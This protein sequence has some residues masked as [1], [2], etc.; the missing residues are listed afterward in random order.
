MCIV[1]MLLVYYQMSVVRQR[2]GSQRQDL[3]SDV[4]CWYST[5]LL[6]RFA[7]GSGLQVGISSLHISSRQ[8][9][10]VVIVLAVPPQQQH[11]TPRPARM[12][13]SA[14]MTCARCRLNHS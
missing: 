1:A 2:G 8:P 6:C 11:L 3:P 9:P 4:A 14:S 7:H 12:K 5:H 10:C 13:V